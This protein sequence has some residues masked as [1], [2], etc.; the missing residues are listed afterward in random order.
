MCFLE[1]GHQRESLGKIWAICQMGRWPV[2][3]DPNSLPFLI[4]GIRLSDFADN[5]PSDWTQQ[6]KS[7]MT[8][9]IADNATVLGN[10]CHP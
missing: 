9:A 7:G 6:Q 3:L 8:Q 4:R 10:S 1:L 5:K 2:F